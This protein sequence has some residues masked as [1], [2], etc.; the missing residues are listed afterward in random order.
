[1]EY[2]FIN[3]RIV[4]PQE[5]RLSVFD[6]GLLRGYGVFDFFKVHDGVPVFGDDHIARFMHSS[7]LLHLTSRYLHHELAAIVSELIKKNN[8]KDGSIRLIHTGGISSNGFD[9]DGDPGLFILPAP[10]SFKIFTN[11]DQMKPYRL[12]PVEYVRETPEIKSLN[13]LIPMMQWPKVKAG[14]YQ[15]VLYVHE[16]FVS[17]SSRANIFFVTQDNVLVTPDKNVLFGITR[18]YILSLAS[19]FMK[20]EERPISME[21]ALKSKE[22]FI[23]STTKQVMPV[24]DL[25]G[26]LINDGQP[27]SITKKL[28]E[29]FYDYELN[30]IAQSIRH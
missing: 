11:L 7:A 13:Y 21:E 6:L 23:S 8:I 26:K 16:G 14:G 12:M 5:A 28:F 22:A 17:E 15:D 2:Y 19:Q 30:H 24:V 20:V 25:G 1:M 9:V 3:D 18:K 29:S 4:S 10:L 27:G